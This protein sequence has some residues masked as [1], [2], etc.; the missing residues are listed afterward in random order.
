MISNSLMNGADEVRARHG[1]FEAEFAGA[2]DL[3][4]AADVH[5]IGQVDENDFIAYGGLAGGAVRDGAG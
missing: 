3:G 2:V 4:A 1:D 5:A